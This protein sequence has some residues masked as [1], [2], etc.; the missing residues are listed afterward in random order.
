MNTELET[1]TTTPLWVSAGELARQ[2]VAETQIRTDHPDLRGFS[3]GVPSI[4][5]HLSAALEPGRLIVVAGESGRGKTALAVQLATAFAAQAPV[6]LCS[7]EDDPV[8]SINRALANVG[9]QS[10]SALRSGYRTGVVPAALH[11][12][13]SE[14]DRLPLDVMETSGCVVQLVRTIRAWAIASGTRDHTLGGCIILD[15]LSHIEPTI[16]TPELRAYLDRSGLPQP[17]APAAGEWAQLE[18]R[19]SILREAGRRLRLLVVIMHQLNHSRDESGKPTMASVA[20]SSGIVKKADAL[21]VPF[22]PTKVLDPFAGPGDPDFCAAPDDDAAELIC[23]K[24]RAIASGWSVPLRWDGAHQRFAEPSE[25]KDASYL[26]P[27]APTEEARV[28]ARKLAALRENLL[29]ARQ[30]PAL[31]E[32]TS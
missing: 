12:A 4:D 31:P 13:A 24:G 7:L 22:R 20:G 28:G 27:E 14:I 17:P 15:Q 8:D 21:L 29:A 1:V 30:I 32:V 9:R 10:V 16:V 3:T 25:T 6:L 26:A 11:D 23:L 5:E 2:A 18:W 19:V